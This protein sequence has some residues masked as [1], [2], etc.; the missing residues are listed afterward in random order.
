MANHNHKMM[1][2]RGAMAPEGA[3]MM[4]ATAVT[5]END[6]GGPPMMKTIQAVN[7]GGVA[8]RHLAVAEAHLARR[9]G[10]DQDARGLRS[11]DGT[12]VPKLGHYLRD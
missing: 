7:E 1:S 8:T 2:A 12:I 4:D 3:M 10:A 6:A 5:M 9:A 11:G